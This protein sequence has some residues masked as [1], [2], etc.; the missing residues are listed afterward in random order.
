MTTVD[1]S[2][3]S[4]GTYKRSL[5]YFKSETCTQTHIPRWRFNGH[6]GVIL[7]GLDEMT[8][9]PKYKTSGP[10]PRLTSRGD[11][12]CLFVFYGFLVS[13]WLTFF[14]RNN[15]LRRSEELEI[16]QK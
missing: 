12:F 6:S 10:C 14:I 16:F 9:V 8:Y 3:R 15:N 11:L 4:L 2:T 13:D 7:T 5:W 1:V